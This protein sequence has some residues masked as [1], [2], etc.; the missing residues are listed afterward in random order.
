MGQPEGNKYL[1]YRMF[2]FMRKWFTP[3]FVNR[4]G[5]DMNKEANPYGERYDWALGRTRKGFYI[6][7]FQT[8]LEGMKT[9]GKSFKYMSKKEK[10]ALRKAAAEGTA[11]IMFSLLAS[12]I[13]GYDDDDEEKWKKIRERSGVIG[14]DEFNTWGFMQN[15]MLALMMGLQAETSAFVPLPK[16]AGVNLG[17]DDYAGLLTST[18]TAFGNTLLLYLEI[19]SDVFNL[20]TFNDLSVYKKE[21]GPYSWEEKDDYKIVNHLMRT[22]GFTGSSGDPETMVKNLRNSS[23]RIGR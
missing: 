3:M 4:F 13:F 20:V 14:S 8:L 19:L 18:T 17:A 7:A 2:F 21:A 9:M 15:H 6:Q 22:F 12:M 11:I 5:I 16:I 10:V 23:S 1:M